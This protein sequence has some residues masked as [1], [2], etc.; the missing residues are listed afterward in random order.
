MY[1][2]WPGIHSYEEINDRLFA[3]PGRNDNIQDTQS[4]AKWHVPAHWR[5]LGQREYMWQPV[6]ITVEKTLAE[7]RANLQ[8][9]QA[10]DCKTFSSSC[11]EEMEDQR[12]DLSTGRH[13][14]NG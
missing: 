7:Y 13:A 9:E 8:V 3:N 4:K 12:W 2:E 14:R 10:K 11:E 5:W 1:T 6:V